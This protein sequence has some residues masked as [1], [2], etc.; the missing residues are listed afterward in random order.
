MEE[1]RKKV[2]NLQNKGVYGRIM[3]SGLH[4]HGPFQGGKMGIDSPKKESCLKR[5]F[6]FDRPLISSPDTQETECTLP[7][8]FIFVCHA[9]YA[10][11]IRKSCPFQSLSLRIIK[12][13]YMPPIWRNKLPKTRFRKH[14]RRKITCICTPKV[15]SINKDLKNET[16]K[17][18]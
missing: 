13:I 12:L 9:L 18:E 2:H 16:R 11:R 1:T 4:L 6:D 3:S 14:P 17:I 8:T 5:P 15:P 7:I 10:S